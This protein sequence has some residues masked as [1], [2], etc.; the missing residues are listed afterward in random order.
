MS[1]GTDDTELALEMPMSKIDGELTF[2]MS[3]RRIYEEIS[4]DMSLRSHGKEALYFGRKTFREFNK[5]TVEE[6]LSWEF[7]AFKTRDKK[8]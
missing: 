7:I 4:V 5:E 1:L 6:K 8:N 2:E 3:I